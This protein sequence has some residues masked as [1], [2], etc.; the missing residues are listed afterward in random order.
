MNGLNKSDVANK[1]GISRHGL[2]K[3]L[4]GSTSNPTASI[5]NKLSN[6][7]GENLLPYSESDL[8]TSIQTARRVPLL[9]LNDIKAVPEINALPKIISSELELSEN[10]FAVTVTDDSFSPVLPENATII[11]EPDKMLEN[12]RYVVVLENKKAT[13][14]PT[15]E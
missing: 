14:N 4:N 12:N 13:I 5:L 1:V 6:I 15:T 7:L 2:Y 3:I 9:S 11:V 8:S 10:A